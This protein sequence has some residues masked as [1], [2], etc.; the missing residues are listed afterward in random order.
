MFLSFGLKCTALLEAM[1]VV[2]MSDVPLDVSCIPCG[3]VPFIGILILNIFPNSFSS[4]PK[5]FTP[6]ITI[7]TCRHIFV[8]LVFG[9]YIRAG[10]S[11]EEGGGFQN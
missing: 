8:G 11:Q 10:P 4:N 5:F 6:Q 1:G 7:T 9:I 2:Y 3:H